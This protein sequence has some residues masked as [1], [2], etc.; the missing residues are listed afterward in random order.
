[1]DLLAFWVNSNIIFHPW[2]FAADF[3]RYIR[4]PHH[5]SCCKGQPHDWFYIWAW[6]K[7]FV[8]EVLNSCS[9]F[10]IDQLFGKTIKIWTISLYFF[11]L[12]E[13][14][15]SPSPELSLPSECFK[16]NTYLFMAPKIFWSFP[17]RYFI[18]CDNFLME[19]GESCNDLR[20]FLKLETVWVCPVL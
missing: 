5:F 12:C 15:P 16:L 11:L 13:I 20:V 6:P 10:L 1:M 3:L 7:P 4:F 9:V 18:T 2:H 14:F 17:L 8:S 19:A